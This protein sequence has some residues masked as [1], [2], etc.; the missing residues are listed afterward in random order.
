MLH[1]ALSPLSPGSSVYPDGFIDSRWIEKHQDR[2]P[3]AFVSFY[4][5]TSDAK[6]STLQDNQL[7]TDINNTKKVL[8][9]SGYKS[10]LVVALLSEK[11][12]VGSSDIEERLSNIRKATGLDAKTSLFFLPPQSS[13][14]E[15]KAFVD[16]ILSITY[17][18]SI[19]YYRD[20]SKHSRRKRNRGIVPPPTSSPNSGVSKILTSQGW[21]VRYDF[22][23]GVFAEFRQEMDAALRSYESGYG[24][25][26]G[27]DV[28]EAVANWSPR[29]NE[30]RLLAD[31]FAIRILRCHLWAGNTTIAVRWWQQ[32]RERMRDFLDRRGKG[33]S[34]YGW[35]AWEARWA[36]VMGEIITK[37]SFPEFSGSATYL[38]ADK[39]ISTGDRIQPWEYLHHPGYWYRTASKHITMR[40]SLAKSIPDEDRLPPGLSPAS[41]TAGKSNMYD[42]FLCPEPHEESPLPPAQGVNHSQLFIDML[43]RAVDEFKQR[44]QIRAMQELQLRIAQENIK[45]EAW[46]DALKVLRL[47]WRTT[48]F[49][50]EGWF[51]AVEEISWA[52]R[53]VAAQV[54]DGI[55]ILSVDW[56]MMDRRKQSLQIIICTH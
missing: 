2:V 11:S 40:H 5:F 47:L 48:T 33:S 13:H 10:R 37:V 27:P 3:S 28:L 44:K 15:L 9:E 22:K 25:L 53:K 18:L 50:K 41:Q 38:P 6:L 49:R 29:W 12:I 52:L 35:Q 16:T 34:T 46:D 51:D 24:L 45:Q 30:G 55:S 54:G 32:H 14:V 31:I 4:N 39:T 42:T 56:E 21:N 19:E 23:L 36:T 26:L 1:S 17:P 20:L 8:A 43:L 7:K